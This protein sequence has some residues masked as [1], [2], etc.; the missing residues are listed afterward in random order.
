MKENKLERI[1]MENKKAGK[2]FVIIIVISMLIGGAAGFGSVIFEDFLFSM[3]NI[4]TYILTI[5]S[6]YA[7]A[8][9][10]IALLS[11]AAILYKQGKKL[12][13]DWDG[14]DEEPI[15][16]VETLLGYALWLGSLN[17]IFNFFFFAAG[18]SLD[19]FNKEIN[20]WQIKFVFFFIS[21]ILSLVFIVVE[22]Q[23]IID[24]EKLMNPEKQGSVYDMH[25]A[26]KWEE[27]CDE[28]QKLKIYKSAYKA[29][30]AVN[31]TCIG[32]W[33]VLMIGS[34]TWNYGILPIAVV[35]IIWA[36]LLSTYCMEAIKLEKEGRLS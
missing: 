30:Q 26:K 23:K 15:D 1:K 20:G 17:L 7:I 28:A 10:S 12:Y 22:Q 4:I 9:V 18:L 13:R 27:S 35:S 29:Y 21:F 6:P 34:L 3:P 11:I 33:C 8:V 32:L 19:C 14:D 36:V 31:M 16:R 2:S 5:I 25:F 24:F